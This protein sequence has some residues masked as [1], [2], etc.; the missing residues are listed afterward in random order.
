[1]DNQKYEQL[2]IKIYNLENELKNIRNI[3]ESLRCDR[4]YNK[5]KLQE[6]DELKNRINNVSLEPTLWR[7]DQRIDELEKAY[8]NKTTN[9]QVKEYIQKYFDNTSIDLLEQIN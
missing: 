2:Q 8:S 5:Q 3:V 1:M 7:L 6:F 9:D 4:E